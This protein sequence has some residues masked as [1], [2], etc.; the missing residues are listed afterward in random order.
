[1]QLFEK[2]NS[3]ISAILRPHA[4]N[5][6][7][8]EGDFIRLRDG[9][10]MFAYSYYHGDDWE[11]NAACEIR[12]IY[13]D[14]GGDSFNAGTPD[15]EARL[16]ISAKDYGEKNVMSVS[17]R[18]MDNGD[19]GL[20]YVLKHEADGSDEYLLSRSSDEGEHF[21]A[22]IPVLPGDWKGYYVVNNNRVERLSSGRLIV[23]AAFHNNSITADGREVFNGRGD[24]YFFASDDDGFHWF[25]M[26]SQL[27][28]PTLSYSRTGM[29]EPGLLELANGGLYAYA[30][31][32]LGYQY[33]ALSPDGGDHWF[34]PQ[35][36]AFTSAPS[37][38]KLA[39]NPYSGKYYAVWN[40][41]PNYVGRK[42]HPAAWGRTPLVLAESRDGYRYDFG[43]VTII[44]DDETRGYCYPAVFF[45]DEK[46]MLLAYCSG[47]GGEEDACLQRLTIRKIK[48]N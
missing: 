9:R 44:E 10:I 30:R 2:E 46:T 41:T 14:D 8:S 36:S 25:K 47:G 28:F 11:D 5:P 19:V 24:A 43:S 7:N 38:M 42:M 45:C 12:C 22:P 6:R 37:P 40:P 15:G 26:P 34:G 48:L 13:S 29:Q 3:V 31:T 33:E 18:R 20:F 32:D 1:V 39:K 27:S 4:G 16:L 17:L 35:P 23:P 21:G